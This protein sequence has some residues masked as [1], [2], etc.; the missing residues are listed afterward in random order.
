MIWTCPLG[1]M[2]MPTSPVVLTE[3]RT[4][5]TAAPRKAGCNLESAQVHWLN[6]IYLKLP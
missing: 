6:E 4:A 1:E 5:V 2:G 3:G